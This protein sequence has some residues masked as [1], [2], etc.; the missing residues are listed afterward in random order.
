VR[1]PTLCGNGLD[2]GEWSLQVLMDIDC[3]RLERRNV[4][5]P[6]AGIRHRRLLVSLVKGVNRDEKSGER[7][8][9]SRRRGNES[10]DT[11]P[12]VGPSELLGL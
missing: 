10:V 3:E 7:L 4:D 11:R 5:D 9:G 6:H 2:L 12:D 1:T 8:S